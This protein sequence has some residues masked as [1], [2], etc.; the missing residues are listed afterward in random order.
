M[1]KQIYFIVA[2]LQ[3][4]IE[5]D[6]YDKYFKVFEFT[7]GNVYF[8]L[9]DEADLEEYQNPILVKHEKQVGV[10]DNVEKA[11]KQLELFEGKV[12]GNPKLVETLASEKARLKT[13]YNIS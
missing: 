13:K 9:L 2:I 3:V 5:K 12:E 1:E 8:E 10:V 7:K 6:K 4:A 11:L